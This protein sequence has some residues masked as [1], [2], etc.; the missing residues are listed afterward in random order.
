MRCMCTRTIASNK[1]IRKEAYVCVYIYIYTRILSKTCKKP[2][3]QAN[4]RK[5]NKTSRP[6]S[7]IDIG[8]Q[9]LRPHKRSNPWPAARRKQQSRSP[10]DSAKQLRSKFNNSPTTSSH[11]SEFSKFGSNT[12][13]LISDYPT[14]PK[15]QDGTT[16]TMSRCST[17]SGD[18]K[19]SSLLT[20]TRLHS[21]PC[22]TNRLLSCGDRQRGYEPS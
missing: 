2:R 3:S 12:T 22:R 14:T 15:C 9:K 21:A 19:L 8:T 11:Q 5:Q 18:R 4:Q 13:R 20:T 1:Q 6:R 7:D 17:T 16:R 10:F